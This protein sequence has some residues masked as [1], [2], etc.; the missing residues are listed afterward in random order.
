[1]VL[2]WLCFFLLKKY[3]FTNASV[4]IHRYYVSIIFTILAIFIASHVSQL[5]TQNSHWNWQYATWRC[6]YILSS[7]VRLWPCRLAAVNGMGDASC[8]ASWTSCSV[9]K[10]MTLSYSILDVVSVTNVKACSVCGGYTVLPSSV[11]QVN[12]L[13]VVILAKY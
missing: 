6:T 10:R 11:S 13:R 9:V 12:S 4:Y 5:Q 2:T 3:L 1:M 7:S 8:N